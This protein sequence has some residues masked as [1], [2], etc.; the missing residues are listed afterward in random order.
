MPRV[1]VNLQTQWEAFGFPL[2]YCDSD[3]SLYAAITR[4]VAEQA[5][6]A[7]EGAEGEKVADLVD[8]FVFG[9]NQRSRAFPFAGGRLTID[10]LPS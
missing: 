6:C 1:M 10:R 3:E 5:D 2:D 8:R 4:I 9:S 7:N